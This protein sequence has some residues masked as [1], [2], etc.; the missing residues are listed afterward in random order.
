MEGPTG[1]VNTG[2]AAGAAALVVSAGARPPASTLRARRDARDP[3]ADRRG[4]AARGTPPAPARPT[5]RR[6]GCRDEQWTRTSA[7]AA[8]TSARRSARRRRGQHPAG[9]GDRL[10]RLVRAADRRERRRSTGLARA[11]FATGGQFHWKLEWGAGAGAD[12][13]DARSREGDSTGAVTDFGS[14]DLNA[15]RTRARDLRRRRPTP[16]ARR[17]PP[18]RPT[19][20]RT[21]HG[22]ARRSPA[23]GIPTAGHRPPR[24]HRGRRPDACAPASRSG[25]APAA[26]RRSATPTSTATTCRS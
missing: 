18:T 1:S 4:R 10:A 22:A 9:G 2:K 14:I 16:A 13:V 23:Q 25:W 19:R 24:A 20:S 7:G 3:R 5:R 11:R 15:V 12:R 8:S 6:P 26:R 17:S 21:V